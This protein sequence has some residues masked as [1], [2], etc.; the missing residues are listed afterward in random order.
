MKPNQALVGSAAFFLA[1]PAV[2]AGLIPALI[3]RWRLGND[4]SA[5]LMT[6][7]GVL[8][9]TGVVALVDCFLRF[10][11]K[12]GTPAPI[13]PTEELVIDGLYR[14]VRNPMYLAVLAINFGQALLFANAALIAYFVAI[15]L[16]LHFFVIG[17]EEPVLKRRFPEAYASYIENVRRWLPRLSPWRGEDVSRP[18]G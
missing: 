4:A 11:R 16:T 2:V 6:I 17:Y 5:T 13:A 15:G 9:V 10:A 8:I 3:S 12:G 14:H 1:A 7:G 18:Q